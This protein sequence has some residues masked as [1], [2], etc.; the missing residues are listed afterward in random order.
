[1]KRLLAISIALLPLF[2]AV[3][4]TPKP[5]WCDAESR[6]FLYPDADYFVGYSSGFAR[7]GESFDAATARIKTDAQGDA[8]QRIQ[9]HVQSSSFDHV[10]SLQR[11]TAQDFDEEIQTLFRKQTQTHASI[12][13]PNL[14]AMTWNDPTSG[15]V[16][17][18]VYTKR[19]DFVR[20]YDRQIE[21]LLGRMEVGLENAQQ[22]EQQGA[23]I[24]GR[25]TAEETLK[26]CPE[27]EYAQRMVALAD[28]NATME[29][30]QMPRYTSLAK[31]L[32]AAINRMRHATAF[33]I[34]CNAT[35]IDDK[36][37]T[38]L[39]REVR[40]LLAEKG[41]QFTNDRETA[42]WVIDIEAEVINTEHK[43]GMAFFAYVDGT[44]T[45][46]NG[47]TGQKILED[48]LST[49]EPDHY[50]GIKGGDFKAE[51]AARIAYHNAASIVAKAILKLVQE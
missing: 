19:R 26:L 13:I 4:Q 37:F 16:A 40:G 42:D 2:V 6:R 15:E 9:V 43:E 10:Q 48:R 39:D 1:M 46:Q 41:C 24:K 21:S 35:T 5:D 49:L 12:E 38:L 7:Q 50:D 8:A 33:Y 36:K 32:A 44:L 25:A 17:V 34:N 51:K 3:A 11:Q 23:Q 22:Q 14:Q 31:Q 20:F 30:L 27:V 47:T 45:V 28:V 18:L 29:D